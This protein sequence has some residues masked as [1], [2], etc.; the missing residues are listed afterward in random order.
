M[1]A[2]WDYKLPDSAFNAS[3]VLK[4]GNWDFGARNARLYKEDDSV[5]RR[6]GGWCAKESK[7]QWLQVDLGSVKVI[8]AVATQGR[9]KFFEHVKSYQLGFSNDGKTFY[10]YKE[11]GRNRI[12]QGNCDHFT[13]V[14][15]QLHRPYS[16]RFIRFYPQTYN[17]VCMRVE[18]Y[19][20]N[21]LG[22][23][24]R[25]IVYTLLVAPSPPILP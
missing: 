1:G 9:D 25:N 14:I 16:A 15:N 5:Y 22:G 17:H 20:C 4:S 7:N 10:T 19:G 8:T 18:I 12:L 21:Q 13:P 23:T 3:T 11:K 24:L 2:G 6:V